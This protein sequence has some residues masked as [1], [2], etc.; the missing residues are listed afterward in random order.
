MPL[1]FI[2]GIISKTSVYTLAPDSRSASVEK[3]KQWH[4][5]FAI[6]FIQVG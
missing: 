6:L 2:S 5:G 4:L 3:S 1:L